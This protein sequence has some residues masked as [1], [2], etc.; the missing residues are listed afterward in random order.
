[1]LSLIIPNPLR[2]LYQYSLDR[3]NT[4]QHTYTC[5]Q[6]AQI[7][8]RLEK[9]R[10]RKYGSSGKLNFTASTSDLTTLPTSA[11]IGGLQKSATTTT[12]VPMTSTTASTPVTASTTMTTPATELRAGS[13]NNE[14]VSM[15]TLQYRSGIY[16]ENSYIE[17]SGQCLPEFEH[18]W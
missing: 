7:L 15:G 9:D 10:A 13:C 16:P 1:M 6:N 12:M 2:P 11:S 5:E 4:R 3:K 8:L 14:T 17:V 18:M